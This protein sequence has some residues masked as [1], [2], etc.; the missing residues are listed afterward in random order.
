[1]TLRGFENAEHA[2]RFG[3]EFAGYVRHISRLI[4]LERL[5]GIT[6]A[7]DYDDAL[8]QLDR[9]YKA[10]RPLTR[11]N[12]DRIVGVAMS[13]AVIRNGVI[14]S[15][16]VFH[17]HHVLPLEGGDSPEF[18]QAIQTVAHECAHVEDLKHRD[19][20]FPGTIL[21]RA[22]VDG[23]ESTLDSIASPVWE[24]YAACRLS[25]VFATDGLTSIYEGSL[26]SILNV[27][28]DR[29]NTAIR[30]YRLHHDIQRVMQEAGEPL[31]EPLRLAAYFIGHVDGRGET[32]DGRPQL[33][34]ALEA[35]RY[36]EFFDRTT[37]ALR[38]LW[39][40]RG[41]WA[42]REEFTPLMNVARDVLTAGGL[43]FRRRD[44][45]NLSIDI[46]LT[47]ETLPKPPFL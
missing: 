23:E 38:A 5:D 46:P 40:R 12:D 15:H 34:A 7:Y 4:D 8:S 31:A 36:A 27:A 13:P 14:K 10:T 3:N 28:R 25:A 24:E 6:L 20:C 32:L 30:S 47:A 45:G 22:Y 11:T 9:G 2:T 33:R 21:Q 37:E 16:L 19:L 43:I 41:K 44:D 18:R 39:L 17:A 29:A 26:I 35:S 42:S 1:M